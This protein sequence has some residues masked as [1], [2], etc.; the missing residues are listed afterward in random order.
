M[1]GFTIKKAFFDF[2]DNL[3][4]IILLNAGFILLAGIPLFLPYW[5]YPIH[6]WASI[7]A[8]VAGVLLLFVYASAASLMCRDMA[9]YR[10]PGFP[11][12]IAYLKDGWFSGLAFG[13]ITAVHLVLLLVAFPVYGAMRNFIGLAAMVFIFW[14]SV[15]WLLASLYYFP[16]RARLDRNVPKILRKCFLLLFDN[17]AFTVFLGSG[18]VL[19]IAVS[20]FAAFLIPGPAA[21]LVW[22]H[23][24]FKLRLLKYDY[25]EKNPGADRKNIPWETLIAE[26]R[27]KVGPRT[28]KGMIF[29]WKE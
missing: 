23:A 18:A 8:F 26:E 20:F 4:T 7:A 28:L 3:F 10:R 5:L 2:W 22:V 11:D 24:G 16:L 9:D 21:V 13:V 6:G 15:L 14:F 27:E 25:L 12:F 29:P 1:T 17:T 19:I